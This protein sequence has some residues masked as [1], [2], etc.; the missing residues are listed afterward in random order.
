MPQWIIEKKRANRLLARDEIEFFI[1]GY[2]K[3][4][5]PDYQMSALA[6]AIAING[7]SE[8]E[9]ASLAQSMLDSGSRLDTARLGRPRIDKHSTGGVGDKVSLVL[10]PLAA[11]CGVAVPMISGRALGLT[12]GTIDKLEAIPGYRVRMEEN[13]FLDVLNECGCSIISAMDTIAPADRKLYALRDVTGTVSSIPLIVSSILSKKL[14]AG[15]DGLVLDVKCG[16][17]AFMAT[18]AEAGALSRSLVETARAL[19]LR[20]AALVSAMNQ[21]LGHNVGNALEVAESVEI[22]QG[23][24]GGDLLSLVLEL[25]ARMLVMGGTAS[26]REK[27]VEML[28]ARLASGEAFERLKK[29]T[30]MHGGDA[31]VLDDCSRL[32]VASLRRPVYAENGGFIREADAAAIGRAAMWLGAGRSCL[33][34]TVDPAAGISGIRKIG[35]RVSAGE[36]L[37]VLHTNSAQR[38]EGAVEIAGG[39]FK[40]SEEPAMLSPLITL[41]MGETEK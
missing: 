38:L 10:A 25:G 13:E 14:A 31:R 35:E 1:R 34:E 9:T 17:G 37:A 26:S 27:V 16:S 3:G 39:A 15:L 40:I 30:L 36:P 21:P 23:R 20:S 24:C 32:P 22:L 2:A 7:M 18:P 5:I 28:R 8:G 6:M 29:M 41:E 4:E 33:D 12:G 19:G 11:C